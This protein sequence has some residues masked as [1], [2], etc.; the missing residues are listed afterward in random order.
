MELPSKILQQTAFNTRA[1]IEEH[2]LIVMNK[3]SHEEQLFQPI[4]TNNRQF[5]LAVTF[6]SSY[7]GI[8]NVTNRNSKFYYK[9]NLINDDFIQIRIP[10]GA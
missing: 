10:E 9:K 5:K 7:N 3:S 8:F 2:M 4:Q 1:K 6:L